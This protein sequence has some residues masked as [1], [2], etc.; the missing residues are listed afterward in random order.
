VVHALIDQAG[1]DDVHNLAGGII[2]LAA[3]GLEVEA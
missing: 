2:E 3:A 1:F